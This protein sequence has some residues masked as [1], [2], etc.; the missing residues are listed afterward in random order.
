MS[1]VSIR[2]SDEEWKLRKGLKSF[3]S[4]NMI[5]EEVKKSLKKLHN[6]AKRFDKL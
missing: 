4:K 6:K 3:Y 2:V 1:K 5:D